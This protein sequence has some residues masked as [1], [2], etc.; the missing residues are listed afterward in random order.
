MKGQLAFELCYDSCSG[1]SLAF[2]ATI[3]FVLFCLVFQLLKMQKCFLP[4]E[5]PGNLNN[6]NL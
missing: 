1:E 2:N 4:S 3:C 6:N 5:I